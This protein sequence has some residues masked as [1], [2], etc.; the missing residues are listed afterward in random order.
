MD[1]KAWFDDHG[2]LIRDIPDEALR[3]CHHQGACDAEVEYWQSELDF[4]APRQMMIDYLSPFG[5]WDI[6]ELN[7]KTDDELAQIVLWIASGDYAENGEWCGL[8]H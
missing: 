5:G 8:V 2:W 3:D 1:S 4:M 7:E 6:D